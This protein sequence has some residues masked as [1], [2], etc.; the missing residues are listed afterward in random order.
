MKLNYVL[1]A[2][3][4]ILPFALFAQSVTGVITDER[5][6]PFFGVNVIEKGTTNG[7]VTDFDGK[8]NLNVSKED[9]VIVFKFL[10]YRDKEVK[11]D[12]SPISLKMQVDEIGLDQVVVSASKRKERL[13]DAPASISVINADK[14][15][16]N[17]AI[18]VADNLKNIPGVDVMPTGLVGANV[19]VRGFNNIFAGGMLTLVDNRIGSVPSLRVNAFQLMPANNSD[20][21]RIE[22]VRGPGS[23]LYGPN[24]SNGV[25]HIITKSPLALSDDENVETMFSLAGGSRSIFN[26]EFRHA[27]KVSDKFGYKIS[28][29]YMQGHDFPFYDPREP[30]PGQSFYFG[31]VE[32]GVRTVIDSARG[33]QTFDRDF[34]IQKYN[35]DARF[36][37]AFNDDMDL[38][39][40]AGVSRT[41]NIELTGLGA[42]QGVGWLYSYA[43]ARFRWKN[44]FVNTFMNSSNSGD[45]YIISQVEEGQDPPY[46]F[47]SLA[48]KSKFYALQVQNSSYVGERLSFT[49][50]FDGLFTRPNSGGT[51]YGRYEDVSDINQLGIYNQ[52]EWDATDKLTLTAA[53]RLDYQTPIEEFQLSPRA[54]IV[55]KPNTRN[56]FR[57]TFNRAFDAPG[58]LNLAI[59]LPQ[60]FIPN[61]ITARG[62]GNPNGFNFRYGENGLA[63]FRSPYGAT[64]QG[65][66]D[67]G[68]T[69]Q[70]HQHFEGIARLISLGAAGGDQGLADIIF[71][72]VFNGAAPGGVSLVE[73]GVDNPI[74][75]VNQ[76]VTDFISGNQIDLRD[77]RDREAV[78]SVITQTAEIGYKGVLADK[79][80]LSVDFYYTQISNFISPLS[81]VSYRVQFN[82][83]ELEN[84]IADVML[85]N[86]INSSLV[87]NANAE[88]LIGA[89]LANTNGL[90]LGTVAPESDFVNSDLV[91]TYL[92]L[93]SVDIAGADL[94]ITYLA[95]DKIAIS[96]AFSFVNKD[97]IPLQGASDGFIGLNAPKYKS[98]LS[99]DVREFG[100]TGFGGGINWRWQDAFPANSALYVGMVNAANLVDVTLS[101]RPTFSE[102]TLFS[103]NLNN[104]FN[105]EF[106]RFPGTPFIGFYA[107]GK[108]Q[109]TFKYKIGKK[110][111]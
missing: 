5:N 86:I 21:E 81:P 62:L 6:Q 36:D 106:Q 41:K 16:N 45:T 93:G 27:H 87:P 94:G 53:L 65:W 11:Y 12:G 89:T 35:T 2:I 52:T 48:D 88:A 57:A 25:L 38:T 79:I 4:L 9:A 15:E 10:G 82:Q 43:Q 80:M 55:Y 29:G 24:A 34:F 73:A 20:I 104:I 17:A 49:Y 70:N 13:L 39:I 103:L 76:I 8:F 78:G 107:L 90:S 61:G 40:N 1:I 96:G 101:Y 100:K 32:D 51:I 99:V 83:S 71:D 42:A 74:N 22:I 68:N 58:A 63:Q 59:D 92:N 108:I 110:N 77:V 98:A 72:Q 19:T 31:S 105:N 30:T 56:T 54:A 46:F 67:V 7:T 33:L 91:L 66:F 97:R 50:G 26:P 18:T 75:S 37:F 84:A 23:A 28:G 44:L 111:S 14:I 85:Q 3:L 102:N 95:T 64:G 47:Q 60:L 69:S 109:H